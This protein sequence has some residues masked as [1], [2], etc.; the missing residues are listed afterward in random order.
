MTPRLKLV[1][2]ALLFVAPP[3]AAWLVYFGIPALKPEGRLNYGS[4]IEPARPLP[5]L[6]LHDAGGLAVP[7]TVLKGKWSLVYL[8]GPQCEA[9]CRQRLVLTRQVRLALD[10]KRKRVQRVY[11]APD[12]ATLGEAQRLLAPEHPDLVFIVAGKPAA[13]AF[14]QPGDPQDLFL[15]DPLANWLMVYR[16]EIE[17]KGLHRDLKKLLHFSQ[18]G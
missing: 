4:L 12:A 3:A 16:G 8:A 7:D 2:L 14:F 9:A 18:I 15:L 13:T 17:P 10:Q 1:L 5:Q 6:A 11:L